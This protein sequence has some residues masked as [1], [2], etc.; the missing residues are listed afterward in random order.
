MMMVGFSVVVV[1]VSALFV[2]AVEEVPHDRFPE[3]PRDLDVVCS[4][5]AVAISQLR[6]RKP[7]RYADFT[8]SHTP[9]ICDT[10]IANHCLHTA[11]DGNTA[12]A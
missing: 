7:T 2:I 11:C 12:A 4:S 6:A 8:D 9:P 3:V 5:R 10:T 1:S